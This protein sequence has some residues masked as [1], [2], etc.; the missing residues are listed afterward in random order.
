MHAIDREALRLVDRGGVTVGDVGIV[1]DVERD[2]PAIVE[3]HCHAG[4]INLFDGT[5][6]A[7]LNAQ[8]AFV[9]KEHDAV[10]GARTS[11]RRGW[12]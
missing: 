7:I 1:F 8:F 2:V 5:K 3:P 4:A 10:L 6:R 9:A 11:A 12:F